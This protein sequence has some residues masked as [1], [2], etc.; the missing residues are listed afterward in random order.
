MTIDSHI[1]AAL[2]YAARIHDDQRNAVTVR[3]LLERVSTETAPPKYGT[4]DQVKEAI[5]IAEDT[6]IKLAG[7][8]KHVNKVRNRRLAHTDPQTLE[9]PMFARRGIAEDARDLNTI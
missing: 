6:L 5:K 9:N 1:S 3:T 7:P 4:R 2:L 8:L